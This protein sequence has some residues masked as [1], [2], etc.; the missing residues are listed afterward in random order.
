MSITEVLNKEGSD[1]PSHFFFG[2]TVGVVTDI[3]DPDKLGRI[4]VKLLNRTTSECETDFI[5]I[6]TP[7]SGKEWGMFFL[8]EVG[9]EVLVAFSEGDMLRPYVIGS[10]WNQTNKPPVTIKDKENKVRQIKTK[11]GHE[12]TFVDEEGKDSITI[13][14]PKDLTIKLEDEKEVISIQNK[15]GNNIVKIDAKNGEVQVLAEKKITVKAGNSKMELDGS[16]NNVVIES[17]QSIKLKSQQIVIDA[18][19]SLELKASS[20]ININSS[21]PTNIKGAITKIN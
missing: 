8:P 16:S 20:N 7:M 11:N 19:G 17:N 9:D 6:L 21:G 15:E 5:R 12:I 14:T 13:K 10:L 4:K 2:V 3:E 18:K 1:R